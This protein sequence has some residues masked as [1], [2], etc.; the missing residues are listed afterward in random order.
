MKNDLKN[1]AGSDSVSQPGMV[2]GLPLEKA[3]KEEVF[4]CDECGDTL[5]D[6]VLAQDDLGA[7]SKMDEENEK[8]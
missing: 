4:I 3:E 5:W 7:V 2:A 1:F 6:K 8:D